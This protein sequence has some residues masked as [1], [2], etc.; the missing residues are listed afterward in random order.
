MFVVSQSL[1]HK[2]YGILATLGISTGI[3]VYILLTVAGL[4]VVLQHS[5]ILFNALKIIGAGYLLYLAWKAFSTKPHWELAKTTERSTGYSAYYRGTITNLLNPKVGLFFVTFL[6]QFVD[7]AKGSVG[8]Q[9][10]ILGVCF[11]IS[12]TLI[13]LLYVFLFSFFKDRL[14]SNERFGRWCNTLTGI[15]FCLMALNVRFITIKN[16]GIFFGS[17]MLYMRNL[18]IVL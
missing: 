13:N 3:F 18:P 1:I 8:T 4:T 7:P 10:L 2:R 6:P 15:V 14:L 5:I 11:M 16:N 9:L 17:E 12:G